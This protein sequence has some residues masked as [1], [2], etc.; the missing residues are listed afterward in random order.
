MLDRCKNKFHIVSGQSEAVVFQGKMFSVLEKLAVFIRIKDHDDLLFALYIFLFTFGGRAH[1]QLKDQRAKLILLIYKRQNF[2]L[3]LPL[4]TTS[5]M[6]SC[7]TYQSEI[8]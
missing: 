3:L 5:Y 1:V 2:T 4:C 6:Y 7:K 8:N